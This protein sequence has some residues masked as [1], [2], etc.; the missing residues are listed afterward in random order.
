M[1]YCAHHANLRRKVEKFG[2]REAG[3]FWGGGSGEVWRRKFGEG[4]DGKFRKERSF[5]TRMNLGYY[6][7]NG[8]RKI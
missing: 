6:N 5:P 4:E 3:K 1:T 7:N 2:E 8:N